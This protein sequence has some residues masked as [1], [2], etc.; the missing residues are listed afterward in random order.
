MRKG[1]WDSDKRIQLYK[2]IK[3]LGTQL[4]I[5]QGSRKPTS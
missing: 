2:Q 4:S 1:E 5:Q 3:I